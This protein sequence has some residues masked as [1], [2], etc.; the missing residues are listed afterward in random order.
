MPPR[1]RAVPY[2]YYAVSRLFNDVMKENFRGVGKEFGIVGDAKE[3]MQGHARWVYLSG[4]T[5]GQNVIDCSDD[6]GR[7]TAMKAQMAVCLQG[8][9]GRTI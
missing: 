6:T 1:Q 8:K 2:L 9:C 7:D 4:L 5:G 3:Q